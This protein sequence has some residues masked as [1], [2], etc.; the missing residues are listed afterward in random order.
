MRIMGILQHYTTLAELE[1]HL[2]Y[3]ANQ[4][5]K[6]L[7]NNILIVGGCFLSAIVLSKCGYNRLTIL[8]WVGCVGWLALSFWVVFPRRPHCPQCGRKMKKM[9]GES[10]GYE[11]PIYFVCHGCRF[12]AKSGLFLT[13]G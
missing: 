2:A 9:I 3:Q 6:K 8:L 4:K 13:A 5:A 11:Q 10:Y 1:A 12:K 7:R